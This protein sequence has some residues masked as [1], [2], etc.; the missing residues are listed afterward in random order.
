[1]NARSAGNE[2]PRNPVV[3]IMKSVGNARGDRRADKRNR[4][5]RVNVIVRCC[6][7]AQLA[8]LVACG[9]SSGVER[10]SAN[11]SR[12]D[13]E[14]GP[15]ANGMPDTN[16]IFGWIEDLV[17]IAPRSSGTP[18]GTAAAAYMKCKFEAL[19][20]Q[21]VHY[22]TATTWKWEATH[23]SLQV[24]GQPIDSFPS[25]FSFVTPDQPSTFSTGASGLNA[26][27]VDI[28]SGGAL[29]LLGKDLTGKIALFDLQFKLPT[30][31]LAPLMEFLW[32]PGLTIVDPSV[33][34]AN[35][36]VTNYS[37]VLER[38]MAAGAAGFVG[39]LS[40]YFDS[41][42]YHNEYYRRLQVTIPG[43]WLAPKD[44]AEVRALLKA[45]PTMPTAKLVL[46][47]SRTQVP[48]HAVVGVL[49]GATA[50]TILVTSH[51]DSMTPGAVEDG[52]GAASVL[53]QAQYFASKPA[54][55]RA[56]TLMFVTMDSHFTGYQVHMA[57]AQ[58]YIVKKET[59]YNIVADVSIEHIGKQAVNE[60]GQ[61]K[62]VDQPEFRGFFE[63][64]GPTLKATMIA[65]I[66]KHDLRR[67]ALLNATVL[68][69]L[70]GIPTDAFSCPAG[71]PTAS[72]ISGPLY[73]YDDA[74]TL[75]KVDK[76][77]LVPVNLMVSELIEAM[78]KTPSA[79]LG[80]PFPAVPG[81][82]A[83]E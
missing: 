54:D 59:P 81:S 41:N 51:H 79:L 9:S 36:Y 6:V 67:M 49:P 13:R 25:A 62:L 64:L 45:T 61:L 18:G 33:L 75:D 7:I 31:G 2:K 23:S 15:Q 20:L 21:D 57:F 60:D 78:D 63:N 3:E 55:S 35:P 27:I 65:S 30:L 34:A 17:A 70:G 16:R 5:I 72:L 1:M 47:G 43:V 28:G 82:I 71:V 42:R 39:V 77:G 44:G 76:E 19:G 48:G 74:D 24:A 56:K 53:A 58:K 40:D 80:V 37:S 4:G 8:L 26:E 66:I 11:G 29:N 68:C 69:P 32:D 73:L 50:D 83:A 52:S 22:E 10:D 38:V 46:E 14:T 12:C